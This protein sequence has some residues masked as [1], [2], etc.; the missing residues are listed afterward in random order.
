M[1]NA[2]W[3]SPSPATWRPCASHARHG[4][5]LIF[6]EVKTGLTI[7]PGGAV[8]RFGV[9]PDMVTLAKALG[10]GCRRARSG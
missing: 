1:T 5:V 4:E 3:C 8:E 6:D 2:A 7:A 10:A 9:R